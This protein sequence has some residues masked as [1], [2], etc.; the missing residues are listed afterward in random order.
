MFTLLSVL[1]HHVKTFRNK[2][3]DLLFLSLEAFSATDN[4]ALRSR[5]W[6]TQ[7]YRLDDENNSDL[8]VAEG[9]LQILSQLVGQLSAGCLI[10]AQPP[11]HT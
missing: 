1:F 8:V 4:T 5:D 3:E 9:F 11:D 10:R 6:L 2:E 7:H